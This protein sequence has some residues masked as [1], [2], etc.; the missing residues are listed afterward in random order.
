MRRV[1][2]RQRIETRASHESPR[3]QASLQAQ[4]DSPGHQWIA[5]VA[6]GELEKEDVLIEDP[7][8]LVLPDT[9]KR[10]AWGDGEQRTVNL[11]VI[12]RDPSLRTIRDLRG[13]HLPVLGRISG[14]VLGRVCEITGV[15]ENEVYCY[16]NYLPSNPV[17]TPP[18]LLTL[19]C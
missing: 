12:F 13:E 1:D 14:D 9:R 10:N 6:R 3:R 2:M 19:P 5:Q 8:F 7:D 17:R 4:R 11:L 15:P 18:V 16:F